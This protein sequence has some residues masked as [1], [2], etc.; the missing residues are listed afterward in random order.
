MLNIYDYIYD[1]CSLIFV[2]STASYLVNWSYQNSKACNVVV[3]DSTDNFSASKV[4]TQESNNKSLARP[5][6]SSP[7]SSGKGH[8]RSRRSVELASVQTSSVSFTDTS[9]VDTLHEL[10]PSV[11]TVSLV[12][13]V[14]AALGAD[15]TSTTENEGSIAFVSSSVDNPSV[16]PGDL[17]NT[18]HGGTSHNNEGGVD[19]EPN[20]EISTETSTGVTVTVTTP[21]P[22]T[23]TIKSNNEA[24]T[25]TAPSTSTTTTTI[26][27]STVNTVNNV[28]KHNSNSYSE[29]SLSIDKKYNHIEEPPA[30]LIAEKSLTPRTENK[31]ESIAYEPA[32]MQGDSISSIYTYGVQKLQ[33]LKLLAKLNEVS[34]ELHVD[35]DEPT[36]EK[37][38][39]KLQYDSG[40]P[41]TKTPSTLPIV[42][43]TFPNTTKE[44]PIT[45]KS[46]STVTTTF[47]NTTKETAIT[48]TSTEEI[49]I[50]TQ[51][52][53]APKENVILNT[54]TPSETNT[55]PVHMT[56]TSPTADAIVNMT[57]ESKTPDFTN[58]KHVMINLTISADNTEN[59]YKP[60]YS[61]TVKV[62]TVGDSNEIPTIKITPMDVEPTQPTNFNKPVTIEGVAKPFEEVNI[63]ASSGGSCEC[64]C[65]SC[66]NTEQPDDFYNDD[67]GSSTNKPFDSTDTVIN[68]TDTSSSTDGSSTTENPTEFNKPENTETSTDDYVTD[69]NYSSSDFTIGTETG[70]YST[71][72]TVKYVCPKVKPPPILIL[73]GEVTEYD[74]D[75]NL[76][77]LTETIG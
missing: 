56:T 75:D 44:T 14:E 61:L 25:G 24:I 35:L 77:I 38:R 34:E 57:T 8:S 10:T 4:T 72:E 22:S 48:S 64:S 59:S 76:L 13:G 54:P 20:E 71:T 65:P 9:N 23:L 53:L 51:Q 49:H 26:L 7:Q 18:K 30:A 36:E 12:H 67:Y 15:G 58:A 19:A 2:L 31:K 39:E 40:S 43:T 1:V 28:D 63:A 50:I 11:N 29:H 62:P 42:M 21:S 73:E 68:S 27:T 16:N 45:S 55:N 17:T 47:P 60:L 52:F 74:N 41:A 33:Y 46:S 3:G 6:Q 66:D 69:P 37:E 5:H 70:S 32:S